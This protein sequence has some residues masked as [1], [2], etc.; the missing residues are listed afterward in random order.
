MAL[1]D[2]GAT[3]SIINDEFCHAFGI[4]IKPLEHIIPLKGTGGFS[5]PY[6]GY[7]EVGLSI[8]KIPNYEEQVLMLVIKD[9]SN[10]SRRVPIQ[11]GTR[12]ID[13][14]VGQLKSEELEGLAEEWKAAYLST[15]VSYAVVGA[16]DEGDSFSLEQVEGPVRLTE[17]V[18]VPPND[19]VEA[20]AQH[21]VVGHSK[22]IVVCTESPSLFAEGRV[23]NA[24]AKW[25]ITPG[26]SK[27]KVLL[28]NLSSREAR[29][30]AKTVVGDLTPC[31]TVPPIIAPDEGND[32]E[33]MTEPTDEEKEQ[34]LAQMDLSGLDKWTA[35]EKEEAL[36]LLREYA[37][38]FSKNDL[39][40]GKTSIVKHKIEV[41]DP[42]PFKER[43]RR[44]PPSLYDEVR[45]HLQQML[46]VGAIRPSHSPWAS[47]VV[48]V[49]KKDGSMRFC[50][51]LRK[52]NARTV[53]DSYSLP[54]IEET[55]DCL[56]GSKLFTSLDLKSG[57][58]QV[59]MAEESKPLTAFTVGPLGFFECHR[60]PF[61]ATNA[62]A[63]FQRL[64]ETCLGDLQLNWCII[65][66][67]DVVVFSATPKD[68]LNRLRA[69]F[70]RLRQAGLKLK[71]S[72]CE[73]FKDS[74]T[75]LGHVVSAEGVSTDPKKVEIVKQW[76]T[77]ATVTHVRSFLGFVNYYRRFIKDFAKLAKPLYC[78]ISGD[79]AQRKNKPVEWG[80]E[81]QQ[82]FE[83]LIE[84]CTTAP[85]LAYA[86]FSLPFQLHLDA[87]GT[88]LGAI[89]YQQQEEAKRVISYASRTLS[90]SEGRYP[91]HKLEFL[92]LKWAVTE[93][94]HE[95]LWGN[96]CDVYTDNN[97]LTYVLT[98]A[99]LDATG[100][101]W[102]AAL[103]S[104]TLSLHYKSGKTNVEADALSR[105]PW[106]WE[107][108]D[109]IVKA[110]LT[111]TENKLVPVVAT[112]YQEAKVHKLPGPKPKPQ[113]MTVED[114]V[115][116]QNQDPAL[117]EI[118]KIVRNSKAKIV[119][120]NSADAEEYR[121]FLR[122][123]SGLRLRRGVLYRK[124]KT[125]RPDRNSMQLCL[126]R[127]FR[128]LAMEGCHDE[129]GHL[130]IER[131]LDLLRD[132]FYWPM[133]I[134]DVTNHVHSCERCIRFKAKQERA[135]LQPLTAS[136]PMELVHMDYLTIESG[137]GGKDVNVLIITDHFTRY[138]EAIV[139]PNQS[140][141][142]TAK[143][144]WD[145]WMRHYG[146]PEQILSDQGRNFESDLIRALCALVKVRK[147]RT[148]SYH[149][150]TNGQCERFNG[151][152]IGML[153]TLDP[154]AK[155]R[156]QDHVGTLVHA[157][158]CTRNNATDLSPYYMWYG[159]K[160]KLAVDVKLGLNVGDIG[161]ISAHKYVQRLERQLRW[162]YDKALKFSEKESARSKKR[163]D[164]KVQCAKLEPGDLV[165]VRRYA[166]TGKHK[167]QDRWEQ[168]IYVVEQ[169][170]YGKSPVFR[171][172]PQEG[173]GRT[174][175]VHRNM[176]LPIT[177]RLPLEPE[178]EISVEPGYRRDTAREPEDAD[179]G[180]GSPP[181]TD[182][183][184]VPD[185][186]PG[187]SGRPWTRSQAR[188]AVSAGVQGFQGHLNREAFVQGLME[189][190]TSW[191][192]DHPH[193]D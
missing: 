190:V 81:A 53:K 155:E 102:V 25:E 65:Y 128:Q 98:T 21:S 169:Q 23:M 85:I 134:E 97:P 104:Y 118:R 35:E 162:A 167:I 48:L 51:D 87:S 148:T 2:T 10:Y 50:I 172:K 146:F 28:H 13:R 144:L 72:K 113:Q 6:L 45:A 168:Q 132:R 9:Q 114:W 156:W 66:L 141:I 106:K 150:M 47:P 71:P 174:R 8:P 67:D 18:I 117:R 140:A 46:D 16:R 143:A 30:P 127:A 3:I 176:L 137:R 36:A 44:I 116:A 95:F 179:K 129:I 123:R 39:D 75:Y 24:G 163:Y 90:Q 41:T 107:L 145:G 22:R 58:W 193:H 29:V 42:V 157:Y 55:L 165:L 126:P 189:W 175:V 147:L 33:V 1:V 185:T 178:E 79:N 54:R 187:V 34:L 70:E 125:H 171:I 43:Y 96:V 63:T 59:E 88:G 26:S 56:R 142:A 27:V 177:Q 161:Q 77:P 111:S 94:F 12:I 69:V 15:V 64:M 166:F 40:L 11:I 130:G 183:R 160:P 119:P 82:A 154:G 52:L 19:S 170:C 138:A 153:G 186:P 73:F 62:P 74:I 99:K 80:P 184:T 109:P 93:Q 110:I 152:L 121:R 139:T 84:R 38:I 182:E 131:T 60:M 192:R 7:A 76:P 20:W 159:R 158:N 133:M 181:P 112:L 37:C 14:V 105:I 17:D 188:P 108:R 92:A 61:G 68:H 124:F 164:R 57:Y 180:P 86:D 89:L 32:Q 103:A 100:Q 122:Q 135:P 49:K 136:Y 191:W 5:I 149:P 151:T 101:R 4:E 78:L 91:A 173:T 31:N 120:L 115:Q 83:Q